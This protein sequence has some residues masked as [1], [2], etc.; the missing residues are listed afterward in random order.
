M[1]SQHLHVLCSEDTMVRTANRSSR[2]SDLV[3]GGDY[4]NLAL[5]RNCSLTSS[6]SMNQWFSLTV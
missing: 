3:Y 6:T 5:D 2:R 4:H 1:E